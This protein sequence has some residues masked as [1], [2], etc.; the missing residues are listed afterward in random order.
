MI[1]MLLHICFSVGFD[2]FRMVANSRGGGKGGREK[3]HYTMRCTLR[4]T[5]R[6]I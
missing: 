4:T 5:A 2:T 3:P 6:T 1:W